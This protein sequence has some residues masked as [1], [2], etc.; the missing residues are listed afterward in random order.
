MLVGSSKRNVAQFDSMPDR[1]LW[2][3]WECPIH[4]VI[5]LERLT[6]QNIEVDVLCR[7]LDVL[8][9]SC[10]QRIMCIGHNM[11]PCSNDAPLTSHP[12]SWCLCILFA[13]L[14]QTACKIL[15]FVLVH[16]YEANDSPPKHLWLH[17]R[18]FQ[19]YQGIS[20][21]QRY[22]HT[23]HAFRHFFFARCSLCLC[24]GQC[25]SQCTDLALQC[26][27]LVAPRQSRPRTRAPPWFWLSH[28]SWLCN[29]LCPTSNLSGAQIMVALNR[30]VSIPPKK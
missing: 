9:N 14:T 29:K 7:T 17:P 20:V 25:I 18:Q 6:K 16:G 4:D 22:Q 26:K 1:K 5:Q 13:K 27:H 28:T 2:G 3:N 11:F 10:C 8:P 23:A 21:L 30:S 19:S 15:C 12:D 24:S